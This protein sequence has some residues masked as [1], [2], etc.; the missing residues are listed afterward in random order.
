MSTQPLMQPA[1]TQESRDC[2][3]K[4]F[5]DTRETQTCSVTQLKPYQSQCTGWQLM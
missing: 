1:V 3:S 5:A 2:S 4:M